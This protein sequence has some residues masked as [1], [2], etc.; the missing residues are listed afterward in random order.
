[1]ITA[2]VVGALL[3]LAVAVAL[4]DGACARLAE[5]KAAQ[6]LAGPFGRPPA[7]RLHGRPFL[8][9]A[10]RGRYRD[11]EIRGD[12][13][14]IGEI[15]GATLSAHL[16]G[17]VLPARELL[18]GRSTALPCDRVAG[19]TVLP[20]GELARITRLPGLTLH[21]DEHRLVATLAVPVPG[22]GQLARAS[23]PTAFVW[24]GSRRQQPGWWCAYRPARPSLSVPSDGTGVPLAESG[25]WRDC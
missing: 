10:I 23:G 7:V 9:Q 18:G 24:T 2:V 8:A 19:Q 12:G 11:I 4:G 17:A 1:M 21:Y 25:D 14:Q 22:V 20:Y 13:L 6:Y 16:Y 15:S 3:V 5:R